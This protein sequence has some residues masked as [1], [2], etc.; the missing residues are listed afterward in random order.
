MANGGFSDHY[1]TARDGL[2]LHLREY[3]ARTAPGLPVVC[4][5][6]LA[7]TAADFDPLASALSG[8]PHRPRRVLA[9]DYRGRGRS[10]HDADPDKYSIPVELNDVLAVLTARGVAS[11]VF[12]GT[13]RG[14]LILMALAALRPGAIAGA[15]LNDIGPVIEPQGLM[16]IKGY[17]GK[18]PAPRDLADG[19]GILRGLFGAQFPRL[20]DADWLAAAHRTWREQDGRLVATYDIRLSRAVAAID[21]DH[22]LPPMWAQFDALAQ[23]PLIVIRGANSDLLSAGTVAA[24]RARRREMSVLEVPDQGHAPLLSDA[25]TIAPI[26]S[27]VAGCEEESRGAVVP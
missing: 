11:A 18:L 8:H 9:L 3:G 23:V 14:G 17:V 21:P 5:P 19:A 1:V 20:T 2:R 7:R 6:G 12:I 22:P 24:M 25:G 26:V 4:L 15:V 16:R 27:F 13:S 10:D